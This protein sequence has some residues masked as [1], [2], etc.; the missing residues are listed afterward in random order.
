MVYYNITVGK[1]DALRNAEYAAFS[2]SE[3]RVR[4][5][6]FQ[7]IEGLA[8]CSKMDKIGRILIPTVLYSNGGSLIVPHDRGG[9]F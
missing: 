8:C 9:G 2:H 1:A 6:K 7:I 4:T 5:S 3:F